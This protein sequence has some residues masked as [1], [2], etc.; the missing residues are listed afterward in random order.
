MN[1]KKLVFVL[2]MVILNLAVISL[3]ACTG[4]ITPT[5]PPTSKPQDEI[6]IRLAPI[7][8]ADVRI[9]ESFPPQVF[10]YIKGGLS[11]GCTTFHDLKIE[12]NGNTINIKVTV[13]SLKDAICTMVYGYFEKNVNLG[14]DFV[15]AET[16]TVKVND[17]TV[18]FSLP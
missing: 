15:P 12:R 2:G 13:Q 6:E 11:N 16:Y 1:K 17:K 7:H 14:T 3:S 18:D 9:A 5:I 4:S 10:V 8:E